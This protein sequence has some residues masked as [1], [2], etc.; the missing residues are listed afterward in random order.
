MPDKTWRKADEDL[1]DYKKVPD[2]VSFK[3]R[4]KKIALE[5]KGEADQYGVIGKLRQHE[6]G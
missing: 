5:P 1:R 6:Q 3:N 2:R 4:I